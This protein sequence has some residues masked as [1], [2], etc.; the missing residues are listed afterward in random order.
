M[1]KAKG[2]MLLRLGRTEWLWMLWTVQM[3]DAHSEGFRQNQD[4][5]AHVARRTS[6]QTFLIVRLDLGLA[7][8]VK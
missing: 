4:R 6:L 7:G 8:V 2:S 1:K 3:M 5:S